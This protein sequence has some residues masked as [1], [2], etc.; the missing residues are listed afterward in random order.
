MHILQTIAAI[1]WNVEPNLFSLGPLTVRWYGLC[2]V[3]AFAFG[4]YIITKL[5]QYDGI[6]QEWVDSVFI[7]VFVGTIIG[8]RLGHVFFYNWSYYSQNLS[9]IP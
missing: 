3:A 6:K 7:Y 2:W 9:E 5:F 4:I 1:N 8:A